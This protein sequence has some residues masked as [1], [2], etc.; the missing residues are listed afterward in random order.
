MTFLWPAM[1]WWL[2]A[3]PVVIGAFVWLRR[4]RR[5]AYRLLPAAFM[6]QQA[7]SVGAGQSSHPF[8]SP[9]RYLP[10]VLFVAAIALL[11]G[12]TARPVTVL[13]LPVQHETV[14]LAMDVSGSMRADDIKP[15][16]IEAAQAA[17][18]AFIA[19]QPRSTR[20]GIVTFA[21]SAS[22]VQPPTLDRND[23]HAALDRIQLQRATALGSALVI[24]LAA[25]FP[26]DGIDLARLE[27]RQR[28]A[29]RP[30]DAGGRGPGGRG[31]AP[32]S[33]GSA[34][35]SAGSAPGSAGS[36]PG[37]AGSAVGGAGAPAVAIAPG[38]YA[39]AAIVLLSDGT[40]TTGY[41]PLEAAK[42]AASKGVRVYTVGI[43][44]PG[45][46]VLRHDGWSMRVTLDEKS[47]KQIAAITDGEYFQATSAPDL[48]GIYSSLSSRFMLEQQRMEVTSLVALAGMLFALMAGGLSVLWYNRIL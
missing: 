36:A 21:G 28:S 15:T 1:L 46:A 19:E 38:G 18:K 20:V 32:G 8:V 39:S 42:L 31:S 43:G 7:T 4:R 17:A 16:R 11:I 40:A 10:P 27:A 33:A 9:L 14:I 34:P 26:D 5:A 45:G 6:R 30:G 29:P 25:I 22:L 23:L 48:A 3:L 24:S 44:T 41:D 37:S 13:T 2:L 12:A 35:G 47:L